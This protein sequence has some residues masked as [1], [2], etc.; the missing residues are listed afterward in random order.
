MSRNMVKISSS[1]IHKFL[2]LFV[3]ELVLSHYQILISHRI[4]YCHRLDFKN[5]IVSSVE[6][7]LKLKTMTVFYSVIQEDLIIRQS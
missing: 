7:F 4:K 3:T 1:S 6:V 5:E 2:R